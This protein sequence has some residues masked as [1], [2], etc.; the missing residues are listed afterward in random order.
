MKA[1]ATFLLILL[2]TLAS[3]ADAMRPNI[4]FILTDDHRWDGFG[5]SGNREI[6]TPNI[7]ALAKEGIV[8]T[9][10]TVGVPQCCPSRAAILTGQYPPQ[11]GY[12]SNKT[13]TR[14]AER[15][16]VEPTAAELLQQAGYHTAIIG[17]WHIKPSPWK[18]GFD[19]V[20]VWMPQGADVYVDAELASGNSAKVR[21]VSG[22]VTELFSDD[23][24]AFLRERP[25]DAEKPFFLW[26]AYTAPH[27]PQKP[28][29]QHCCDPYRL[30]GRGH[31]PPGFP[32][33][34]ERPG[35]WAQY[36]AAIT[37]LDEQV[38]RVLKELKSRGLQENT[39]VVFMGDNGWMMGSHGRY[40]KNLPQD[41]SARV[42]FILR[43][44]KSIQTWQGVSE[45][46]VSSMDLAPTWVQLAGEE[47]PE[48]MPG[49][50]LVPLL[51]DAKAG[52]RDYS[53]SLF[54][55]E[56][57][58]AGFAFRMI[59]TKEFKYI[60]RPVRDPK[61]FK[62][63]K[64][65][66][67]ELEEEKEARR[68]PDFDHEQLFDLRADPHELK[69]VASDPMYADQVRELRAKMRAELIRT[70]DPAVKWLSGQPVKKF[71]RTAETE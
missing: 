37:H 7:D 70:N 10:G 33:N 47:P 46:L 50:S 57:E 54:E 1:V 30:L 16:F 15:G 71:Q 56:D 8:F 28:V 23:A 65:K 38:G 60:L 32:P 55:D 39:V 12:F 18:V 51:K 6:V 69:N 58:F 14:D 41:E 62:K 34:V 48:T 42:P 17:K 44:P 68:V 31:Q 26:L 29:P 3:A 66:L 59:R 19:E 27:T 64:K 13:W 5:A 4:V 49:S 25:R 45:A 63:L 53:F 67:E 40:G 35:P 61:E 20:R 43:A 9:H 11:N 22:H 24:V 52:F 2:S 36:Y 21:K